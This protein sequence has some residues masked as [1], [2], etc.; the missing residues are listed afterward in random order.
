MHRAGSFGL[1]ARASAPLAATHFTDRHAEAQAFA[2]ALAEFRALL[3]TGTVD[4]WE[5]KNLLTFHGMGGVGKT[6]LAERL[7]SWAVDRLSLL[8]GWGPRPQTRVA[9]TVRVDLHDSLGQFDPLA[10]LCGLRQAVGVIQPNWGSFDL[11]LSAYWAARHPGLT[12]AGPADDAGGWLGDVLDAVLQD[13]GVAATGA[14]PIGRLAHRLVREARRRRTELAYEQEHP[15]FVSF[16]EECATLPSNTDPRH[17]LACEIATTLSWELSRL[18]PQPLVVVFVDAAERLTQDSSRRAEGCLNRLVSNLPNLLFVVTG[19]EELTWHDET[20]SDLAFWGSDWWPTLHPASSGSIR[21]HQ[22]SQLLPDDRLELLKAVR[23]T[24][25]LPLDDTTVNEICDKSGGLP[26]FIELA[27]QIARAA[28]ARGETQVSLERISRSIDGLV[29]RLLND[30]PAAEQR[31]IRAGCLLPAFD[32][33]LVAQVAQVSHGAVERAVRRPIVERST[34][35]RRPYRV[36]DEIRRAIRD[37]GPDVPEGWSAQDWSAAAERGLEEARRRHDRAKQAAIDKEDASLEPIIDALAMA[38]HLVCEFPVTPGRANSQSYPDWLCEALIYG[39]TVGSL[40]PRIPA[41]SRT[42]YG[43]GVVAFVTGK[44]LDHSLD[45]RLLALRGVFN[46]MHPLALP[47]GRHLVYELRNDSRWEEALDV[48]DEV[49][50][51]RPSDLHRRQ[52]AVTL[53]MARRFRD[54]SLIDPGGPAGTTTRA[55]LYAHGRPQRYFHEVAEK[56]DDLRAKRRIREYLEEHGDRLHRL[57]FF[58]RVDRAEVET[59]Y[60]HGVTAGHSVAMRSCLSAAIIS[61]WL[62]RDESVVALE[63]L[64]LLDERR[65]NGLIGVRYALAEGV[66]AIATGSTDR[67]A[68]LAA[69]IE[70]RGKRRGRAWIPVEFVLEYAGLPLTPMETQWLEPVEIVRERWVSHLEAYLARRS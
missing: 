54:A 68:A 70:G 58:A 56:I 28:R 55:A 13:F 14:M 38:I 66:D 35:E 41:A 64:R 40:M 67:L 20:R 11:A 25:G 16:L 7:R 65:N 30:I 62:T 23:A 33:P 24:E 48:M 44:S 29:L 43:A 50:A 36:H 5:R 49:I 60:Q 18:H 69:K 1:R 53:S 47:A 46:S 3:D 27:V 15:G 34:D 6:A 31:A 42:D 32:I 26:Q 45:A 57:A 2:A 17:D 52:R 4:E 8:D 10:A 61:G 9:A 19:R 22:L 51:R 63:R 39:P 59:V 37:A 21:Q 12:L